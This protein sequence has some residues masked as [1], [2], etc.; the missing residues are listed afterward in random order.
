MSFLVWP[1]MWVA[2]MTRSQTK[3]ASESVLPGH[4]QGCCLGRRGE[5]R[6]AVRCLHG[7]WV[8]DAMNVLVDV[9]AIE[10]KNP[11]HSIAGKLESLG[12]S[13]ARTGE[14]AFPVL[15]HPKGVYVAR[16]LRIP[17]IPTGLC[18]VAPEPISIINQRGRNIQLRYLHLSQREAW[19]MIR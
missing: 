17:S 12:G 1:W 18:M 16:R 5:G 14:K 3:L 8:L 6:K 15:F 9:S 19:L 11:A 2:E 13:S 4:L 10:V 7:A